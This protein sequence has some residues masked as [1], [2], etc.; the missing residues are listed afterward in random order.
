MEMIPLKDSNVSAFEEMFVRS[1]EDEKGKRRIFFSNG[2]ILGV[3][4]EDCIEVSWLNFL[5]I[6][7]FPFIE[8]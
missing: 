4:S 8:S 1:G 5:I 3:E 6:F 2:K 7:I